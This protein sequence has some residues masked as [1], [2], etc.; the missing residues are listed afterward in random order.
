MCPGHG[1]QDQAPMTG[2]STSQGSA[3][4]G[5]WVSWSPPQQTS[6]RCLFR[7]QDLKLEETQKVT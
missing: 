2:G 6:Q 5:H 3:W 1:A 7:L 4:V